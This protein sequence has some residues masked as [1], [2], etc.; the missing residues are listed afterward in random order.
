MILNF[1]KYEIECIFSIYL[2][3]LQ[4]SGKSL[5]TTLYKNFMFMISDD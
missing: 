5:N 1:N 3:A 2:L 4:T